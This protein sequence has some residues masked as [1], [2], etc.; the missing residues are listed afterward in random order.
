VEPFKK[1]DAG[2]GDIAQGN[3][4]CLGSSLT[5]KYT[6]MERGLAGEE[7]ETTN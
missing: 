1:I 5:G 6:F 4:T 7:D 2:A 3:I